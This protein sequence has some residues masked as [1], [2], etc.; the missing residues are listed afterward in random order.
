MKSDKK[1][2]LKY[3]FYSLIFR[4]LEKIKPIFSWNKRPSRYEPTG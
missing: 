2:H 4:T 1:T 3:L